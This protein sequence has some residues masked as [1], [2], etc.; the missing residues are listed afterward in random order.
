MTPIK[1]VGFPYQS[2]SE[3]GE[4]GEAIDAAARPV[5]LAA[6]HDQ[7]APLR[8]LGRRR[9]APGAPPRLRRVPDL[10]ALAGD[11][12]GQ[13]RARPG[14]AGL[15]RGGGK[16]WVVEV[17]EPEGRSTPRLRRT[18][19]HRSRHPPLLPARAGVASRVF[20][21]DSRRDEFARIP[22]RGELRRRD[23][24]RRRERAQRDD[25]PARAAAQV[26][27]H[28]LHA[29]A[30]DEPRREL[31]REPRLLQPRHGRMECARPADA[32]RLRQALRPRRLRPAEPGSDR[33]RRPLP[34][35]HRPRHR[36]RRRRAAARACGVDY[37]SPEGVVE[38]EHDYVANCTGF[39]LLAQL[40]TLF[41][42]DVRE[43]IERRVGPLWDS[44][45]GAR[46]RSAAT[47]SWR[48][49]RPGFRSPAWPG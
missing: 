43:E 45:A 13:P 4:A 49:C 39:D 1:D 15:A 33:L 31:P 35:R 28:D 19:P 18:G 26:P 30:A 7:Q 20:H 17:E 46:C 34:L 23:R 41:P 36:R 6:A 2:H 44:P 40:R 48:G 25:V 11:R 9:L 47:S 37:E 16:R 8:A 22:E 21:C 27:L 3:F 10:G 42:A 29:D 24:R 12:G 5:H 32:A 14:D 38:R